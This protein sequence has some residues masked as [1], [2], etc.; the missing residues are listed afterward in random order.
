MPNQTVLYPI[1]EESGALLVDFAGWEMPVHYGSQLSEHNAV[2]QDAG[3]FDVSHMCA[4][5]VAGKEAK[6]FLQYLLANDVAKLKTL[7]KAL[8]TCMLNPAGGVM[9]DLIVYHFSETEYRLV[10]NAGTAEKDLA[11]MQQQ[12]AEFEV[13]L[14]VCDDVAIIAVQGPKAIE[15]TQSVFTPKQQSATQALKP[16]HAV[17][18]DD[19]MIARTGYTGEAGYEILLPTAAAVGFWQALEKA[20][21]KPC[22][23]GARDTLRLE[24][25]YNLYG[26]DMDETTSP[27]E[28]NLAWTLSL[29]PDTRN[30]IGRKAL[31]A[32]MVETEL[33]GIVLT[34]RG[35]LRHGQKVIVENVGEGIVTSGTFSPT[36]QIGIAFARLPVGFDQDCLVEIR[37]KHVPAKIVKVPFVK[38]GQKSYHEKGDAVL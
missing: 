16:F 11:W 9:D 36:L 5:E 25:G 6:A 26:H 22:G 15:K 31:V 13:T 2:R 35:V 21:V 1:H 34:E 33:V 23:L 14:T 18:V 38:N 27:L 24:A 20:G 7:G 3:L 17:K 32:Q 30:F 19:W 29:K 4:L 10:V 28:A 8:Y 37:K 12:A